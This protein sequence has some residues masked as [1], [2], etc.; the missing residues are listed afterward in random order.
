MSVA[1]S[2]RCFASA[3]RAAAESLSVT[4]AFA[5]GLTLSRGGRDRRRPLA[6][7]ELRAQ[8]QRDAGSSMAARAGQLASAVSAPRLETA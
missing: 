2:E 7:G 8:R 5:P 3:R 6:A 1:L 4:F